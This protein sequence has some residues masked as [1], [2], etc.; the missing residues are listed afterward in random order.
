MTKSKF[1]TQISLFVNVVVLLIFIL[2]MPNI[3]EAQSNIFNITYSILIFACVIIYLISST[4]LYKN[5]V[6]YDLFFLIGF[7]IVHFQTPIIFS[8]GFTNLYTD[9]VI[10]NK[11]LM[12]YLTWFSG[13]SILFWMIGS[14]L[15][16]FYLFSRKLKPQMR[17]IKQVIIR[18]PIADFFLIL[19]FFGFLIIA[20]KPLL[21]GVYD[22]GQSWG[23]NA[24]Y[25][26]ML[27]R[28]FL[29]VRI[30]YFFYK[31]NG[32]SSI[33]VLFFSFLKEKTLFF[34]TVSYILLFFIG[35]QRSSIL[36]LLILIVCGFSVYIKK[37]PFLVVFIGL[38]IGGFIFTLL[39]MGR[40]A[41]SMELKGSIISRGLENF[42][43]KK[44]SISF[45][46]DELS[47]SNKITYIAFEYFPTQI[48]YLYGK[49]MLVDIL[50]VIPFS[51]KLLLGDSRALDSTS[52][53]LFTYLD[54]GTHSSY[55]AGSEVLADVYINW[56]I[57]GTF[58]VFF[59]F[60]GFISFLQFKFHV[61]KEFYW[62]L[63]AAAII[64]SALFINRA[65]LL[66]PLK[67]VFYTLIF[68]KLFFKEINLKKITRKNI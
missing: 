62:S 53:L 39:G 46:T 25:F 32:V 52:T 11:N 22:G 10:L 47:G 30:F 37:I 48:D 9:F 67:D 12:N 7:C 36:E 31:N 65:Q 33:K 64:I 60:G 44:E 29:I 1:Y 2:G 55:G 4:Q 13:V 28:A 38:I 49:T 68:V 43:N 18:Q 35:G 24:T 59:I 50:G 15:V 57:I 34:I 6:K 54:Q 66:S 58:I 16:S 5:S 56:G 20:G 27:L 26:Y 41:D 51:G 17:E 40:T 42:E 63:I 8:L 14:Q 19:V 45:P 3:Y 61:T 21:S 23:S